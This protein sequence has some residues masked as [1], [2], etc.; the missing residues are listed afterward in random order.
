[1]II[2]A[3]AMLMPALYAARLENWHVMQIFLD[4]ALLNTVL[5]MILGLAL[6]NRK[7]R[8][9]AR[10]HLITVL[11][12]Y[13]ILPVFLALPFVVLIPSMGLAQGYFEMLS[14]LT[15]TGAS[16]I[17]IP[18]SI[19]DPLHL[20]RATVGWMGGFLVLIIAFSIMEPMNLGGFEIQSIV[21]GAG[22][23]SRGSYDASHRIIRN[24]VLIGPTYVFATFA[25][26]VLLMLSGDRAF[27]AA[28]HAM[29]I[30]STSGISAIGG[31]TNAASGRMGEL[32][33]A[34]F[35]IFAVSYYSFQTFSKSIGLHWLRRDAEI[36]M[37]LIVITVVPVLLFLRHWIAAFDVNTEQNFWAALRTLWGSVFTS[38]SFLT[39]AGFESA[40]WQSVRNWSG[41]DSPGIVLLALAMMGGGIATTAGGVKLL[42]IY[43]LYKHGI[44]EMERLVHP[45]SIGGAGMSAR[46]FRREGAYI[47]WVFLMLFLVSIAAIMLLLTFL[48]LNFENS[49]A[50]SI[51]TLTNTGPAANMLDSTVNYS[52]LSH[53][54]RYI[55]CIAMILGRVEVLA[56]VALFNPDY[57]RR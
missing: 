32:F 51:A 8:I 28:T 12:A 1:M 48:G 53:N 44:R 56:L 10:S 17:D 43:A 11:L 34:I 29:S 3:L 41:L 45:S 13:T 7:P 49:I 9:T 4:F 54:A 33:M 40:D 19:A 55:L 2:G 24:V 36:R 21:G 27:V 23:G 6:M 25:L 5:A 52:D 46:R 20:W 15:T 38:L 31:I 26:M 37:M 47:A 16:L 39:T 42:R 57:W 18:S 35:L 50:L 14:A 22:A 30:L